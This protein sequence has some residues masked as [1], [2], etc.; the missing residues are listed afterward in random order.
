M[1]LTYLANLSIAS[2]LTLGSVGGTLVLQ[3]SVLAGSCATA[4]PIG[5]LITAGVGL[6]CLADATVYPSILTQEQIQQLNNLTL[7]W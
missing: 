3:N 2:T 7:R 1:K 6:I 4:N 5:G